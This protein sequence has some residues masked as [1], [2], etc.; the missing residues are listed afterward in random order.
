MSRSIL[1]TTLVGAATTAIVAAG[2]HALPAVAS[3]TAA[4]SA[5]VA[6]VEAVDHKAAHADGKA[7]FRGV[8]FYQGDV[9]RSL[10][11]SGTITAPSDALKANATPDSVEAVDSLVAAIEAD[12]PAFFA[13]LSADL[14]SGDPYLVEQGVQRSGAAIESYAGVIEDG[15]A[16]GLCLATAIVVVGFGWVV[17]AADI[18]VVLNRY[19]A[20]TE[21]EISATEQ[22]V[23]KL[24]PALAQ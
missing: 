5:S 2:F 24:T 17:Y 12:D 9:A 20:V 21:P 19:V 3:S 22:L 18:A 14:R 15:G 1:R 11:T 6:V 10:S 23:A 4:H 8:F 7:L 13:D 16:E